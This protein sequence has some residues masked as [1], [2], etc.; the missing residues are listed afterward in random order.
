MNPMRGEDEPA[1]GVWGICDLQYDCALLLTVRRKGI[2]GLR[3]AMQS[4]VLLI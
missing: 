1:V 2:A 4:Q 3:Q